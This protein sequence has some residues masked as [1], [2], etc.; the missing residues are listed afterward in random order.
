MGLF[1]LLL[2][3]FAAYLF[4]LNLH[5]NHAQGQGEILEPP[6]EKAKKRLAR[7]ELTIE[8]FEEIKKLLQ[9]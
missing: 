5:N 8:Q 9:S 2:I 4:Y 1:W 7:G 6:L 3:G